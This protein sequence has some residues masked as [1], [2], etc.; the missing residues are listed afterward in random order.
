MPSQSHHPNLGRSLS[1]STEVDGATGEHGQPD[2]DL[3]RKDS[4]VS[5]S[6]PNG[7]RFL[8]EPWNPRFTTS[9]LS[10]AHNFRPVSDVQVLKVYDEGTVWWPGLSDA[11][12]TKVL[13]QRGV[14]ESSSHTLIVFFIRL[15]YEPKARYKRQMS[16]SAG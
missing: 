11:D 14:Q 9:I 4:P 3:L 15:E 6:S 7:Q 1:G 8:L 2:L 12:I 5:Y 10:N 13:D 16:L